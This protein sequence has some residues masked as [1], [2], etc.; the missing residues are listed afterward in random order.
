[1]AIGIVVAEFNRDVTRKLEEGALAYLQEKKVKDIILVH[2][3]GAYEIPLAA[4]LLLQKKKVEAVIALGAVIRGET[5]HYESVCNS[6]E[7][8]C[9]LLQLE[10]SKPLVF[11]VLTTENEEQAFDRLG[12]KHGHKGR[13]AAET[14]LKMMTLTKKLKK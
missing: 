6:V 5:T 7:R 11:G 4:K 14:A 1:M 2:V 9:T 13:D 10:F 8:G 12:G 3:P